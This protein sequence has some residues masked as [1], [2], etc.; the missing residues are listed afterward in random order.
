[1]KDKL[2]IYCYFIEPASYT[3][4]KIKNVYEKKGIGHAFLKEESEAKTK[5]GVSDPIFL[6]NLS[7]IQKIR[8]IRST[9]GKYDFLIINGLN[10]IFWFP[11]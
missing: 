8:C 5:E 2:N 10:Q 11:T 1:M 4:D 7:L 6:S 3:V 9:R